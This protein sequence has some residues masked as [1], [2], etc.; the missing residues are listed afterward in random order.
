MQA[1]VTSR[2]MVKDVADSRLAP[3]QPIGRVVACNGSRATISASLSSLI[4]VNADI[5]SIGRLITIN[6]GKSRVVGLVSEM[7][8]RGGVWDQSQKNE[9][10]VE[11]E[12]VGEVFDK[13]EGGFEFRRG[14][15][16]YPHLGAGAHR[17]DHNDLMAVHDL[18]ERNAIEVGWLSQDASIPATISVDD[19]LRCHFAVVGTTGVG[20]SSA[21]ALLLREAVRK[22]PDLRVVVLLSLIHI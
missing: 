12:L 13:K 10:E 7:A 11:I 22:K 15:S 17:I 8:S 6:L 5:W 9:I 4:D 16:T 21:V 1:Q 3:N 14:I 20:K 19:M 18:G 2:H